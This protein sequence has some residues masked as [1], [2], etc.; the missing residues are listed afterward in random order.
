MV[1]MAGTIFYF[2]FINWF[3]GHIDQANKAFTHAFSQKSVSTINF[4]ECN[5]QLM[6]YYIEATC[7]APTIGLVGAIYD[8]YH[9]DTASS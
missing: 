4:I 5:N 9:L 7:Y 1:M 2:V 3:S 8:S 6:D